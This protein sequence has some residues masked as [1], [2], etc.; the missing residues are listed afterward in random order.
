[1]PNFH[2]HKFVVYSHIFVA[3]ELVAIDLSTCKC[4]LP[5]VVDIELV[6]YSHNFMDYRGFHAHRQP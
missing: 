4:L 3:I 1:M 5:Q 2:T 6:D